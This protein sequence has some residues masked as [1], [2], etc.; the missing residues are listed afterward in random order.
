MKYRY[1][2]EELELVVSKSLSIAQVCREL[3]IRPIGGNYKTITSKINKY[4]IDI[5]HFTGRAWN[6]GERFRTIKKSRE[7]SEILVENS[8]MISTVNLKRRLIKE[9][10]LEYKCAI[11]G[12][13]TWRNNAIT[14]ELDHINGNNTDNRLEN[15]RLLCPNC[16]SQTDTFR[17]KTKLSASS[18]RKKVEYL[19]FRETL[20]GNADGNPEPSLISKEGAE[21][22]RDIP[23][24]KICLHCGK[25]F[26]G[27]GKKFCSYTCSVEDS[28]KHIPLKEELLEIFKL[29]KSFL[30]VSK[31]YNVSDNAI[32]K[33]C[34][35][36]NILDMVKRKSKPLN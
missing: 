9:N 32:R 22:L 12:I 28:R 19:K 27:I 2:K 1:N 6:V 11:C 36:Y 15:L 24:S 33:W 8:P 13:N 25:E 30:Q 18:E 7:L 16:H 4:K 35:R 3:G 34:I 29:K 17:G 10:I 31:H 26:I 23:K 21:T 14:L 20:T 5:S